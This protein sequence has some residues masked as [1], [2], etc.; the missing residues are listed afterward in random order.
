MQHL[1]VAIQLFYRN[2]ARANTTRKLSHAQRRLANRVMAYVG[3]AGAAFV[4]VDAGMLTK[5]G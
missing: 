3:Q 4:K 2:I 5:E 1:C